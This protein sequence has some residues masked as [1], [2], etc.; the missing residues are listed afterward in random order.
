M[1]AQSSVNYCSRI[2]RA[3][4]VLCVLVSNPVLLTSTNNISVGV[5]SIYIN[6]EPICLRLGVLTQGFP[7]GLSG[8]RAN[9]SSLRK[10]VVKKKGE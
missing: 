4:Q 7:Y 9:R 10:I 3:L 2:E 5:H 6:L 1:S 8:Q